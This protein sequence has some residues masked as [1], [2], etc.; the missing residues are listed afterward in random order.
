MKTLSSIEKRFRKIAEQLDAP[1]ESRVFRKTPHH[2]GS[3]HCEFDGTSYSY[4]TSER[5]EC[6]DAQTTRDPSELLF[7]LVTDMTR[8]MASDFELNNRKPNDDADTRL[9]MFDQHV[10]LL[11]KIDENWALKIRRE[12]DRILKKHP[13]TVG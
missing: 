2:D 13:P 12:Y 4:I 7:W 1:M 5:G 10:E 11:S 8:D 3:R 6:F 9:A